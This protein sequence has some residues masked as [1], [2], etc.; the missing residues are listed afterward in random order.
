[1]GK[2]K[3]RFEYDLNGR[4]WKSPKGIQNVIVHTFETFYETGQ[5]H[6]RFFLWAL[7]AST[8]FITARFMGSA[9]LCC[10]RATL[11]SQKSLLVE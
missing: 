8:Y 6:A 4:V 7:S 5:Q 3:N 10:C 9:A 1:M 2:I 11:C